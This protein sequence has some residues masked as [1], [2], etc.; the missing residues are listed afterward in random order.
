MILQNSGGTVESLGQDSLSPAPG[1]SESTW[2][3]ATDIP[4]GDRPCRS[5]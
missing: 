1:T 4:S 5:I 3:G 2:L